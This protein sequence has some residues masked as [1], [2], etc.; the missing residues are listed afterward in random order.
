[1]G[2]ASPAIS[3]AAL[4]SMLALA[5]CGSSDPG[6][7]IAP[8]SLKSRAIAGTTLPALYTCDG[9]DIPPTL[10]WGAL[11]TGTGEVALIVIGLVPGRSSTSYSVSAEWAVAGISPLLHTLPAGQPLPPG[12]H[13]G[14]GSDHRQT[15]SICPGRGLNERYQ[16]MLYAVP[17]SAGKV[18]RNFE[19]LS[20]LATLS[21]PGT[22]TSA[23]GQGAFV[24]YYKRSSAS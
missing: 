20:M 15:Y 13:L 18:P 6:T 12:A 2:H 11:P 16:F 4:I 10:E 21:K 14:V 1:M 22:T 17:L 7:S 3:C 19:D 9:R 23:I 24:V 8:V 5:G